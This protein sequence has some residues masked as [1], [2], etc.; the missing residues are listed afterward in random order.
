[1]ETTATAAPTTT[2]TRLLTWVEEIAALTEP[3]AIHRDASVKRPAAGI[4]NHVDYPAHGVCAIE[5]GT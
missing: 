1:M 2:N 5:G 4:G 3:A